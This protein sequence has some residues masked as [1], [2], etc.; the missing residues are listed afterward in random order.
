[1]EGIGRHWKFYNEYNEYNQHVHPRT[2]QPFQGV[3]QTVL[4]AGSQHIANLSTTFQNVFRVNVDLGEPGGV[5][6]QFTFHFG[7]TNEQRLQIGPRAL[8]DDQ[9]LPKNNKN[10][11][12][13]KNNKNKEEECGQN[14][15]T[16]GYIQDP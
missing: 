10:K 11:K 3:Q 6:G 13:N 1:L 15:R 2:L 8:H 5:V 14:T 7:R 9:G 4:R 16:L 12:N